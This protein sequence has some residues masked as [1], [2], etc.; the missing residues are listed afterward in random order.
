M[1]TSGRRA[2]AEHDLVESCHRYL[3]NAHFQKYRLVQLPVNEPLNRQ[4]S[5][6]L[7]L[8]QYEN[9]YLP[10]AGRR[11]VGDGRWLVRVREQQWI[12][13]KQDRAQDLE[14]RIRKCADRYRPL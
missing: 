7:N 10:I 5:R 11:G 9:S 1:A 12:K 14:S 6:M 4:E 2:G 13:A 8:Q 3:G